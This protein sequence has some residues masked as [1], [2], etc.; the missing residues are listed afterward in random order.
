MPG[1]YDALGGSDGCRR[2]S[3]AF[4]ARV[5]QDPILSP[6]FPA[7]IQCA[8]NAFAAF[9]VQFLGGPSEYSQARWW[10]SLHES[11][12]R[13]KIG[14][15]ERNAWMKCMTKTLDNLSLEESVRFALRSFFEQSSAFLVNDSK[16]PV[17]KDSLHGEIASRWNAQLSV[18]EAVAAIR[19]GD[20]D[21]AIAVIEKCNLDG[22]A[23]VH[24]LAIMSGSGHPVLIDYVHNRLIGDPALARER[25]AYGR[26]L[27]HA[28]A[29]EGRLPTV[30]LLLQ[31]GADP[32]GA[33]D[34]HPPLY[35]V[36]NECGT[37]AG[38]DVV[39]AL[40]QAGAYVNAAS[41]VKRCTPL[42]MAARRGNISVA[43]ALLEC[44]ANIQARDSKGDSPLRRALNCRK[45]EM[46]AFLAAHSANV[47]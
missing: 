35:C 6:L 18:E 31:L 2:L 33:Q 3:E 24:L 34:A 8:I 13:F 17:P 15:K 5:A 46:A 25:Y 47:E 23:L 12:M 32:N 14:V 42:H 36:G 16:T 22:A 7:H 1:L 20:A 9:L 44:G 39:R 19:R 21:R 38:G 40:V 37:A 26:T 10:L 27:L 28:A 29:G 43:K 30:Q 4:Y 11:H 45:K 41:G